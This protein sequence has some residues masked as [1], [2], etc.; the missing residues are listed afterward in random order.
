MRRWKSLSSLIIHGA[1]SFCAICR[2][3]EEEE[4][5][6]LLVS[7]KERRERAHPFIHSDGDYET[8]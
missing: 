8:K 2:G 7:G 6:V 1:L 3:A 4:E 5:K